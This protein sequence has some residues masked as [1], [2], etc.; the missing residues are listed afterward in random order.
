MH[1]M[2]QMITAL[3]DLEARVIALEQ[4]NVVKATQDVG[5]NTVV[6]TPYSKQRKP[7]KAVVAK[8]EGELI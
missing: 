1:T 5:L 6:S 8:D 3:K 2:Q 7:P 4:H